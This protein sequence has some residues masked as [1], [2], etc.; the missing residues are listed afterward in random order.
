MKGGNG[1]RGGDVKIHIKKC[2]VFL[3]AVMD[4]DAPDLVAGGAAGSKG[5]HGRGGKGASGG[6]GGDGKV[7]RQ[8]WVI[9]VNSAADGATGSN[10]RS[11][12]H[13]LNDGET[14]PSGS[15]EVVVEDFDNIPRSYP[16]VFDIRI[17]D[18][19]VHGE[20][21]IIGSGFEFG[22]LIH[23]ESAEVEN[24]GQMAFPA[25][26][27]VLLQ[28]TTPGHAILKVTP[29]QNG[30]V[31][32]LTI[33]S[34]NIGHGEHGI[35]SGRLGFTSSNPRCLHENDTE[36]IRIQIPFAISTALKGGPGISCSLPLTSLLSRHERSVC[37]GYPI[38]N[39]GGFHGI[40]SLT[41]GEPATVDFEILNTSNRAMGT[42]SSEGRPVFLRFYLADTDEHIGRHLG[43]SI[44][45]KTKQ[46]P[47]DENVEGALAGKGYTYAVEEILPGA[48]QTITAR[49]VLDNTISSYQKI[50]LQVEI[51]LGIKDSSENLIIQRRRHVLTCEPT[52]NTFFSSDVVLVTSEAISQE[53]YQTWIRLLRNKLGLSPQIFS[54]SRYGSL[55]PN[56]SLEDGTRLS[57]AFLGKLVIVLNEPLSGTLW[58]GMSPLDLIPPNSIGRSSTGYHE[59]TRWLIVSAGGDHHTIASKLL[60]SYGNLAEN[61]SS[62]RTQFPNVALYRQEV[63]R[64]VDQEASRGS[65]MTPS[66]K[67][68]YEVPTS[69]TSVAKEAEW[70]QK[71]DGLRQYT[72]VYSAQK[73]DII[74]EFCRSRNPGAVV[75]ADDFSTKSVFSREMMLGVAK[76]MS[77]NQRAMSLVKALQLNHDEDWLQALQIAATSELLA[78]VRYVLDGNLALDDDVDDCFPTLRSLTDNIDVLVLL[79]DSLTDEALATRM[80][81]S[82]STLVGRLSAVAESKDLRPR[83]KV[84]KAN[85]TQQALTS[86]V[87]R[88]RRQWRQVM[89]QSLIDSTKK[90][91]KEQVY[92]LLGID[93]TP[94][95]GRKVGARTK[96]QGG[97][98]RADWM[99]GLSFLHSCHNTTLYDGVVSERIIDLD[100]GL[101]RKAFQERASPAVH[102]FDKSTRVQMST[103]KIF[104]V[105]MKLHQLRNGFTR[106]GTEEDDQKNEK[107]MNLN[108][109]GVRVGD[110]GEND[111][112]DDSVSV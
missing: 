10:G 34:K 18:I 26:N 51:R 6:I 35:S 20:C 22:S 74:I 2:D 50:N 32:E 79:R 112:D 108:A 82:L 80:T 30:T 24:I 36:P 56:F 17:R 40:T 88:I 55:D 105:S 91:I 3:L 98:V 78:E 73:M 110:R 41:K 109:D 65:I 44:I 89:Q 61:S 5:K 72:I 64:M 111:T 62:I 97:N 39:R 45:D 63:Q 76:A 8:G 27:H 1:G 31:G 60:C 96:G 21:T 25:C 84:I 99:T 4:C 93:R 48:S 57:D 42:K 75:N 94:N 33:G 81:K 19:C 23:F 69:E 38:E 107:E 85:S 87:K 49:L 92:A 29:E 90:D 58:D 14:G 12:T 11:P 43:F 100:Q 54:V 28:M 68:I 67:I 101:H 103:D 53:Q 86:A 104:E 95:S 59:T 70:L 15:F 77:C 102:V 9:G 66:D 83:V 46:C 52:E 13:S 106:T 37:F 47:C 71:V 7:R 16:G